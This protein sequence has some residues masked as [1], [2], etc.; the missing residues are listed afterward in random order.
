MDLSILPK[1]LLGYPQGEYIEE[2]CRWNWRAHLNGRMKNYTLKSGG[3][4]VRGKNVRLAGILSCQTSTAWPPY[5]LFF[6]D[7]LHLQC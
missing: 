4:R 2:E 3:K 6:L 5:S 7:I 1:T